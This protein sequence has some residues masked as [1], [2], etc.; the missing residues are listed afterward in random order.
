MIC[1]Y[2]LPCGRLSF[3]LVD[4]FLCC[5]EAFQF[6]VGSFIYFCFCFPYLRRHIQ[7]DIAKTDVR[8]CTAYVFF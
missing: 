4:G 6:D 8:E 2:L 7:K 5:A 3:H 1:Q